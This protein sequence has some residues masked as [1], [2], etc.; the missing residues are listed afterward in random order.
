MLY[1]NS[2]LGFSVLCGKRERGC[3]REHGKMMGRVGGS[4]SEIDE[5]TWPGNCIV[6]SF[7]SHHTPKPQ[8]SRLSSET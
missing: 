8:Y 3:M 6:L 7:F 4:G 2:S 1:A 5:A